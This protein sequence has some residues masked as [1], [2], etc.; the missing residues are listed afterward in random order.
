MAAP[1]LLQ[2]GDL[3]SVLKRERGIAEVAAP[4]ARA[5]PSGTPSSISTV[6]SITSD[7][8]GPLV[9]LIDTALITQLNDAN[10]YTGSVRL[11]AEVRQRLRRMSLRAV[12][13]WRAV[14][15]QGECGLLA[16]TRRHSLHGRPVSVQVCVSICGVV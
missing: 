14:R 5:E 16:A 1:P 2:F 3:L 6:V 7:A 9:R 8:D 10:V 11:V 13:V 4:S 12:G 15:W